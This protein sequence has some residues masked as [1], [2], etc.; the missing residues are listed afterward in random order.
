MELSSYWEETRDQCL[1]TANRLLQLREIPNTDIVNMVE[2]LTNLAVTV[3]FLQLRWEEQNQFFSG[4][5]Q[6][7]SSERKSK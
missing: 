2:Q 6:N 5:H 1:V 4:G 7:S 3:D